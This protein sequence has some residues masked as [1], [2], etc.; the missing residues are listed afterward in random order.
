MGYPINSFATSAAK[1]KF[2]AMPGA[3][4]WAGSL[5]DQVFLN[6]KASERQKIQ[7][8]IEILWLIFISVTNLNVSQIMAL[9]IRG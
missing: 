7:F 6:I 8:F 3:A 9:W 4:E 1:I 5:N 2:S